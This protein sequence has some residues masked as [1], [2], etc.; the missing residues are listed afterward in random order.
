MLALEGVRKTYRG[1]EVLHGIDLR[2]DPGTTVVIGS[3]GSGKSTLLRLLAGL[4]LADAGR[5]VA[6][7][8]VLG[9]ENLI[10]HRRRL[11]YVIQE[12]GLFPHLTARQNAMLMARYLGRNVGWTRRRLETLAGM[13]HLSAALLDRYPAELSGGERQR[14]ALVR[15]LMLEPEILLLDEPLGALDPLVRF[16]LMPELAAV[17]ET[18]GN[19]VVFVTHDLGEAA[20]FAD[21]LVLMHDGAVAQSGAFED[22]LER[23]ASDFVS[24]FVRAQRPRR[25]DR[26][27]PAA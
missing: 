23:P 25:E 14:V 12:G 5:V 8:G 2:F 19:I 9:P 27:A 15:A 22:L 13:T 6:G 1:S 24:R 17:F 20:Y 3:S 4:E 16:E 18:L 7:A 26:P 11:G 10:A 21:R